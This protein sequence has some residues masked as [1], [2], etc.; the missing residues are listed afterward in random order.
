MMITFELLMKWRTFV[1]PSLSTNKG[2]IQSTEVA[3]DPLWIS[4]IFRAK[5]YYR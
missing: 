4:I 1:S 2:C 3:D 5:L